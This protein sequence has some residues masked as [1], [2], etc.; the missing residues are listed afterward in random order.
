MGNLNATEKDNVNVIRHH[1]RT[2]YRHSQPD[3][4]LHIVAII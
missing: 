2:L 3:L 1:T 4:I